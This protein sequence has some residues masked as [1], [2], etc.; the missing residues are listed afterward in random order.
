MEILYETHHSDRSLDRRRRSRERAIPQ[1]KS[2]AR[3]DLGQ[4]GAGADIEQSNDA[5]NHC[6]AGNAG[7]A[8]TAPATDQSGAFVH[9]DDTERA[10]A[11][12]GDFAAKID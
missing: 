1:S 4:P 7:D 5:T 10:G 3:P 8:G 6:A 9:T 11:Q 2:G 12:P